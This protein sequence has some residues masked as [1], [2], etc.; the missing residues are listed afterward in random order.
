MLLRFDGGARGVLSASQVAVGNLNDLSLKVYGERA[1]LE[2]SGEEPELLRFTPYGEP[3]RTLQRGGPGNTPRAR[4]G[5][6]ACPAGIR[7][8]ISKA[9]PIS[10]VM[11]RSLITARRAGR[12]PRAGSARCADRAIDGARGVAFIEAAVASSRNNGAWTSAWLP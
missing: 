7:R 5:A 4:C 12:A 8:A 10:I 9:S 2:W 3:T 6:R 1:G 11:R